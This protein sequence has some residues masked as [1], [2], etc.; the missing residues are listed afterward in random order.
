MSKV[1][2]SGWD[3]NDFESLVDK[4]RKARPEQLLKNNIFNEKIEGNEV[5]PKLAS[6]QKDQMETVDLF[7]SKVQNILRIGENGLANRQNEYSATIKPL[8]DIQVRI[9]TAFLNL[10]TLFEELQ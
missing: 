4:F 8:N 2:I 10:Q 3:I 7:I 9:E 1:A 5:L 6:T